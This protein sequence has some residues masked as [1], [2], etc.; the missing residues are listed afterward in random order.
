MRNPASVED[1]SSIED[2]SGEVVLIPT[3]PYMLMVNRANTK[4]KRIFTNEFIIWRF[5][6]Q[7][8]PIILTRFTNRTDKEFLLQGSYLP[9]VN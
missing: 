1:M 7:N 9:K 2:G 4:L 6:E 8:A 3:C 5:L